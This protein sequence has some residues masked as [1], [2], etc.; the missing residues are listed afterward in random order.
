[1]YDHNSLDQ[2][3]A[4]D[5]F[6]SDF[7]FSHIAVGCNENSMVSMFAIDAL[8]QL[9]FKFLEKPELSDFN[10]QRLFLKPFLVIM[11]RPESRED[12]RELVLRCV[13]N[14][15]RSLAHNLRSGWKIFFS[16]LMRSSSDPSA[17]INTLGLA[18][19][20]R[21]LDEHLNELC[22]LSDTVESENGETTEEMSSLERR[23]R[24]TNAEDFVGLCR[25]SLSFVQVEESEN[26]L[27]I[28]LSMRALCH[29]AC[30]A[31]LIAEKR[32]LPP[33]SGHQCSEQMLSGFTYEGLSEEESLEMALWRPLLDGLAAGMCSAASSISGGVGCLVQR[34]SLMALR[35]ILLRH[36]KLFSV[37]QWSAIL[38]F[39]I[40]P[41]IQI[42]AE[43]D[44]S[45]VLQ[46]LSDSPSVSSL[47]FL[48]EPLPLPPLCDDEGLSKFAEMAQ[49]ED[50]SPKRNLGNAEL[51]VEASFADLR[52]G[53]DGNL[54]KAH[55]LKKKDTEK[56]T[57]DLQPF[58]DSWI[59]TTAPIALGMVSDLIGEHFLD[60]GDEARETLWP[61]I[62]DLLLRWSVGSFQDDMEVD[63][64]TDGDGNKIIIDTSQWQPCEALVRIGCKEWGR[65]LQSVADGIPRL[66][67]ELS[68]GWLIMLTMHLSEALDKNTNLER[69]IIEDIVQT[70]LQVM[71]IKD[72]GNDSPNNKG[73]TKQYIDML[74]SLK[75]RCVASH[76]LQ[77]YL[78]PASDLPIFTLESQASGVLKSLK[79][80]RTLASNARDNGDL[81]HAFQDACFDQ[82]GVSVDQV[83]S[84]LLRSNSQGWHRGSCSMFFLTQEAGA[85][86][87]EILLLA[88][89]Y[90]SKPQDLINSQGWGN[91]T[92]AE[93]LLFERVKEVLAAFLESE[94]KDGPNIDP[95]IWRNAHES[96][97]Q[98]AYMCTSYVGVVIH[99][100]EAILK[101]DADKFSR[102]KETL[103]PLLCSLVCSQS[104]EIRHL[105][106]DIFRCHV[107]PLIGVEDSGQRSV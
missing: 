10:F 86:K 68:Q 30:Y 69:E 16:I 48:G 39:V 87:A 54:S 18:I 64:V 76:C 49:S 46:I 53:G 38:N 83:D 37:S 17:K 12:T 28:G 42:G 95:N 19:L 21:L 24:N 89:L 57:I 36:G 59:A 35:A 7:S 50:S 100:L 32:V 26:P 90:S 8:R 70:K 81:A 6:D 67:T 84:A 106:S 20:Q 88:H 92:F 47:D 23:Q 13:D 66:S 77:K 2:A 79:E 11:E 101:L 34:G 103:F 5:V 96:G 27:P 33:V 85:S 73:D 44:T 61:S 58:P 91:V 98:V 63:R 71:G 107:G 45:P 41:A 60:L 31:D 62:M 93:P 56:K 40:L 97:C 104:D 22:R 15:I 65:C 1:M 4:Y 52:H 14:I 25:A 43:N 82:W 9:S 51:L 3:V 29:T 102:H 72:E 105:V 80:S 94:E 55:A 99:I 78:S 74:P 75:I